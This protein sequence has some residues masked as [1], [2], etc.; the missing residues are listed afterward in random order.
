MST[1]TKAEDYS[2]FHPAEGV[3]DDGRRVVSIYHLPSGCGADFYDD[4]T[5]RG[6][7]DANRNLFDNLPFEIVEKA[8]RAGAKVLAG[9]SIAAKPKIN[10]SIKSAVEELAAELLADALE[11][12]D[13]EKTANELR[14]GI[15]AGWRAALDSI[16]ADEHMP[17]LYPLLRP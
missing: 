9:T 16:A 7:I 2:M 4:G 5:E 8:R 12:G 10:Q 6:W 17:Q 14:A 3:A 11:N 13:I 15:I 1:T